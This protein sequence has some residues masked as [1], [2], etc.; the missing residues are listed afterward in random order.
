MIFDRSP[1]GDDMTLAGAWLV[2]LA[3]AAI[4]LAA[5]SD[6]VGWRMPPAAFEPG[7]AKVIRSAHVLTVGLIALCGILT[8]LSGK[9][10]VHSVGVSLL[11]GAII[12]AGTAASFLLPDR[13]PRT[14]TTAWSQP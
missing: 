2:I 9:V 4:S 3:G 10:A 5:A 14:V 8:L 12:A 6:I 1:I 7:Y 11:I 13:L